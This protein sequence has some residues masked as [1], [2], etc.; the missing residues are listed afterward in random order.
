MKEFWFGKAVSVKMELHLQSRVV[1]L[2]I[3]MILPSEYVYIG[4]FSDIPR[5]IKIDEKVEWTIDVDKAKR[6][7]QKLSDNKI[8][9]YVPKSQ[10]NLKISICLITDRDFAC[11]GQE[12][13]AKVGDYRINIHYYET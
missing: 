12:P 10:P 9:S 7:I 3:P 2:Y 11:R 6:K 1:E 8:Y 5:Y 13:L 4:L